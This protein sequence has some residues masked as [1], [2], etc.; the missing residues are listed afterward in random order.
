MTIKTYHAE[1]KTAR[2]GGR[3]VAP[4]QGAWL[5]SVK[6]VAP[7]QA[8]NVVGIVGTYVLTAH[9]YATGTPGDEATLTYV[10]QS[11][12]GKKDARNS[13]HYKETFFIGPNGTLEGGSTAQFYVASGNAVYLR[14]DAS[15]KNKGAV[16]LSILDSDALALA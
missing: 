4:G 10:R 6:G 1:D 5:H 12:P 8:V 9:V 14:V 13:P 2:N 3:M 16:K 15:P 7:S 11:N